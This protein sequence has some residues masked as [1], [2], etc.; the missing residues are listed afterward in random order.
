MKQTIK[1]QSPIGLL[2]SILFPESTGF[3]STLTPSAAHVVIRAMQH[4]N[5]SKRALGKI[6]TTYPSTENG[7]VIPFEV[8][9]S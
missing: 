9:V 8:K 7:V 1:L 4:I 2:F 3:R 5:S 6:P